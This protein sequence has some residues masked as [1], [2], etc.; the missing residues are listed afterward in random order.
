MDSSGPEPVPG[1]GR[2]GGGAGK[3]A[4]GLQRLTLALSVGTLLGG[5]SRLDWW[6]EIKSNPFG[7]QVC[8]ASFCPAGG[9]G[10]RQG[11]RPD[12]FL[13][14]F[15]GCLSPALGRGWGF[16]GGRARARAPF[17]AVAAAPGQAVPGRPVSPRGRVE[18]DSFSSACAK[19]R[20]LSPEPSPGDSAK[21]R[22]LASASC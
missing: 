12:S 11:C 15:W 1:L 14:K 3:E 19:R 6:R 16:W 20:N 2:W 21:P 18:R 5:K 9:P 17:Q 13:R 7:W 10:E 4:Q 8:H 22:S